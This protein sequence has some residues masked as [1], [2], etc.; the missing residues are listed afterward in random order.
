MPCIIFDTFCQFIE[1]KKLFEIRVRRFNYR[2]CLNYHI[3]MHM[4][5][6]TFGC[7]LS[8]WLIVGVTKVASYLSYLPSVPQKAANVSTA[9]RRYA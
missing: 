7:E 1:G 5:M 9:Y 4:A 2:H 3:I 6:T 8:D